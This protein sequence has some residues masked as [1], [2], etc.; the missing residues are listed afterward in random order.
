MNDP[1]SQKTENEILKNLV[2]QMKGELTKILELLKVQKKSNRSLKKKIKAEKLKNKQ[3]TKEMIKLMSDLTRTRKQKQKNAE[4]GERLNQLILRSMTNLDICSDKYEGI[5]ETICGNE[6]KQPTDPQK[7]DKIKTQYQQEGDFIQVV[8]DG[9]QSQPSNAPKPKESNILQNLTKDEQIEALSLSLLQSNNFKKS[10]QKQLNTVTNELK[11]LSNTFE[12]ITHKI[13][14]KKP[15][16]NLEKLRGVE[17][18]IQIEDFDNQEYSQNNLSK[19]EKNG[20]T[21]DKENEKENENENIKQNIKERSKSIGTNSEEKKLI[22][23]QTHDDTSEKQRVSFLNSI[24]RSFIKFE[25]YV[26]K[27]EKEKDKK[28]EQRKEKSKMDTKTK[29]N[30]IRK[31]VPATLIKKSQELFKKNKLLMKENKKQQNQISKDKQVIKQLLEKINISKKVVLDTSQNERNLEEENFNLQQKITE[32]QKVIVWANELRFKYQLL[33]TNHE[34]LE[35]ENQQLL[36]EI[37]DLN[38]WKWKQ[39]ELT[40]MNQTEE[41]YQNKDYN[42]MSNQTINPKLNRKKRHLYRS[43]T[44]PRMPLNRQTSGITNKNKIL[45]FNRNLKHKGRTKSMDL[46][47]KNELSKI[48]C[49]SCKNLSYLLNNSQKRFLTSQKRVKSL[50]SSTKDTQKTLKEIK[51]N[52]LDIFSLLRNIQLPTSISDKI[53]KA[54]TIISRKLNQIQRNFKVILEE[55]ESKII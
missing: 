24:K 16:R 17:N 53:R 41:M 5:K 38:T 51:R 1:E 39:T 9:K 31:K 12:H 37:G 49:Q 42:S 15:E 27:M 3:Q 44:L 29:N 47:E 45:T 21:K 8:K 10:L 23:I 7:S 43:M 54:S 18:Q 14:E 28:G 33:K 20:A 26:D 46:E 19:N 40:K 48:S 25:N 22:K 2:Q 55:T 52:Q 13:S 6:T 30:E 11:K 50:R 35:K 32:G 36:M 4:K 34:K